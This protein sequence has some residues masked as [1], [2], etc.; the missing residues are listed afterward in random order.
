MLWFTADLHL[1]HA[2]I[3]GYCDRP[4]SSVEEMDE[5]IIANI[6]AVVAPD[7][8]LWVLGD[9][10]GHASR[11]R[12]RGLRGRIRCRHV[13]LVHGNH[14]PYVPDGQWEGIW[15]LDRA[16]CD[17][18]RSP[19]GRRMVLCHYPICDWR[20]QRRGSYM[21]HGHIHSRGPAYNRR[22]RDA[23]ILRYDV[24]VDANGFRPVSAAE[25]DRWFAGVE[26]AEVHHGPQGLS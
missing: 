5:A 19:A 6:N 14:D 25:I 16:Y 21:L 2:G 15:E 4:F 8:E 10:T 7:D 12:V 26:P 3:I 13:S 20:G 18:P 9:F 1:G 22:M 11:G 24:G 17:R 23:G